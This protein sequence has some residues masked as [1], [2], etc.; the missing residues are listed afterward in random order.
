VSEDSAAR[1]RQA[2]LLREIAARLEREDPALPTDVF[3]PLARELDQRRDD[4][5]IAEAYQ[6]QGEKEAE[7]WVFLR[8]RAL[9]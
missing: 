9:G 7:P 1:W 4:D 8:G 5:A 3:E 6:E 2:G